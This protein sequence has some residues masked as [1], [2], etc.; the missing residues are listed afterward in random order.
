[1]DDAKLLGLMARLAICTADVI[2][3]T[4]RKGLITP[5]STGATPQT[6]LPE[7]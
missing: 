5:S 4:I 6:Q 3:M 1:M 2:P 7:G